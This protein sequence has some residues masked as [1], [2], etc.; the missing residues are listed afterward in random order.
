ME[1]VVL[2]A[3]LRR[4]LERGELVV[5]YQ[6][7]VTLPEGRIVAVEAL[8]RWQHPEIGLVPPDKFIPLSEETGLIIP[9][10]EWILKT[11]CEQLVTWRRQG[12]DIHRVAVNLSGKQ[13]QLDTLPQTVQKVLQQTGCPA[14]ALELEITE[15]FIMRH[16]EQS[17]ALLKQI[18]G[19]GVEL[20][21]DDFGTGHSSLNYLKRLPI[22]RLKIDRSFVWDIGENDNGETLT[23]TI[24]A[25]GHSLNLQITAEGIE[26]DKQRKFLEDLNCNEAQGYLFSKPL[27]AEEVTKLLQR[28]G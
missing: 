28:K 7:Q 3:Q 14:Y 2:E 21:V 10:G 13:I 26:T 12:F 23:R 11:A 9:M 5:H 8:M 20:S 4:A 17:I 18:Q 16:P 25:M 24:I 19:L 15:G 22:N 1:K 6:P 27:P